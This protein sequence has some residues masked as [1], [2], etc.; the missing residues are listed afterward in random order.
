MYIVILTKKGKIKK[1]CLKEI[2][3]MGREAKGITGIKLDK[4]DEVVAV[5]ITKT[6]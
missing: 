2:R 6:S 1:V 5:A 4:G 3:A